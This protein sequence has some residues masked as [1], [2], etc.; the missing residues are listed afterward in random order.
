MAELSAERRADL[1]RMVTEGRAVTVARKLFPEE[2]SDGSDC[3][4]EFG[5]IGESCRICI[6]KNAA[7]D[8][9]VAEVRAAMIEAFR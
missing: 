7:W 6:A 2:Y 3:R 5:R 9:R 1:E 4:N 8:K